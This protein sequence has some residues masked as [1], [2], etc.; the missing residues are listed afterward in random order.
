MFLPS[1]SLHRVLRLPMRQV[2]PK[3]QLWSW[4]Q[5]NQHRTSWTGSKMWS[6]VP[7]PCESW[8]I[9]YICLYNDIHWCLYHASCFF[10][11]IWISWDFWNWTRKNACERPEKK[12]KKHLT[13]VDESG[14][15]QMT[16]FGTFAGYP[17]GDFPSH[18]GTCISAATSAWERCFRSETETSGWVSSRSRW[19]GSIDRPFQL[20]SSSGKQNVSLMILWLRD[21]ENLYSLP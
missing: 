5:H 6:N 10:W 4:T 17:T 7:K 13:W 2:A 9:V 20:S 8:I 21:W 1:S 11:L 14:L 19:F 16:M 15:D 18:W 12:Q 3:S